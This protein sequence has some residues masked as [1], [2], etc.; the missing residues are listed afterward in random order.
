MRIAVICGLA[1]ALT[2][3]GGA[4]GLYGHDE[5]SNYTQRKE[6]ITS[7]AG[8]A[9]AVNAAIHAE[10]PWP[11]NVGDRRIMGNGSRAARAIDCYENGPAAASARPVTTSQ[12]NTSIT[13]G[14]ATSQTNSQ[15]STKC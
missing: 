4:G 7:S 12:T 8:D 11:A 3:C 1:G 14:A 6:T 9:K 5:F 15:T 13:P 2:G 10:T